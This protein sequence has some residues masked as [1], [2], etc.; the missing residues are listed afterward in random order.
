MLHTPIL[1]SN[2]PNEII[3]SNTL[4]IYGMNIMCHMHNWHL[5]CEFSQMTSKQITHS[6]EL[7]CRTKMSILVMLFRGFVLEVAEE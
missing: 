3:R 1:L 7:H 6:M 2:F 4:T 5:T